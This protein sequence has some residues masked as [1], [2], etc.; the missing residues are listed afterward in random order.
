M[1]SPMLDE[2]ILGASSHLEFIVYILGL[3]NNSLSN[4]SCLIDDNCITKRAI[5]FRYSQLLIGCASHQFN[6]AVVD[7]L[8][9]EEQLACKIN[10]TMS[11]LKNLLL[12]A[13]LRKFTHLAAK[14]RNITRCIS[15][16]EILIRYQRLKEFLP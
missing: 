12:T 2:D 5:A 4:I 15:T 11:K 7:I 8:G 9:A 16:F 6:L 3:Y 13:K 1:F 14:T 10:M